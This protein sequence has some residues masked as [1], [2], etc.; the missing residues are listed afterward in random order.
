MLE[1]I[2]IR[3][4]PMGSNKM[5]KSFQ[6]LDVFEM[7]ILNNINGSNRILEHTYI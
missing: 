5:S 6:T 7:I 3:G 1:S 2:N 4:G